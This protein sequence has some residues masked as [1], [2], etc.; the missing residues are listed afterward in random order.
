MVEWKLAARKSFEKMILCR[1]STNSPI[2]IHKSSLELSHLFRATSLDFCLTQNHNFY[3]KLRNM[4]TD[5]D[6]VAYYLRN[7]DFDSKGSKSVFEMHFNKEHSEKRFL[8]KRKDIICQRQYTRIKQRQPRGRQ[9]F[10]VKFLTTSQTNMVRVG[11]NFH[12]F[13]MASKN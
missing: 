5:Q 8:F 6:M 11:A 1:G 3:W 7:W 2:D 12:E 13:P 4:Q 10:K 9:N